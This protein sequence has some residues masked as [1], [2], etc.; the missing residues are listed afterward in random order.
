MWLGD[1]TVGDSSD[2]TDAGTTGNA[3]MI[4]SAPNP[5]LSLAANLADAIHPYKSGVPV[6]VGLSADTQSFLLMGG[7]LVGGLLL[8]NM[9]NRR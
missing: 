5:L 6:T 2:G 7:I 3:P 9:V 8:L 1:I 4:V